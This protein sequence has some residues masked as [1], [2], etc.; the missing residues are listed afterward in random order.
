ML[1]FQL[2]AAFA[3]EWENIDTGPEANSYPALPFQVSPQ[4]GPILLIDNRGGSEAPFDAFGYTYTHAYS[5]GDVTA[6]NFAL[7]KIIYVTWNVSNPILTALYN[8]KADLASWINGGGGII[9]NGQKAGGPHPYDFLPVQF[10]P[11]SGCG[12]NIEILA[13]V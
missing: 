9:V 11:S 12:E 2:G 3:D 1:S 7:Y 4:C 5:A 6:A 13:P 10:V 8:R